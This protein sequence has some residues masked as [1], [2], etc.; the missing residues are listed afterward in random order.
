MK[1]L[2]LNETKR[3]VLST[4][5]AD[6]FML[7]DF[8]KAILEPFT[9]VTSN[10]GKDIRSQLL[11]AFNVW[12]KVPS[13][14]L[15]IISKIVNMLHNASLLYVTTLVNLGYHDPLDWRDLRIDDIQDDSQLRRGQPGEQ[16]SITDP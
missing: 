15:E 4:R 7:T 10:P 2:G 3:R 14:K 13:D 11:A 5:W 8:S 16:A 1:L 12:L 9:Y 6:S